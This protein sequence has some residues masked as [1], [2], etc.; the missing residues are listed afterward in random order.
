MSAVRPYS[1]IFT[2]A[3][4]HGRSS[5][6]SACGTPSSSAMTSTG[7]CP[8]IPVNRSTGSPAV[9]RSTMASTS[10]PASCSTQGRS[11]STCPRA[12]AALISRRNRVWSGGSISR[13][14]L[15]WI[16]LNWPN[17]SAGARSVQIRP[18]ARVRSTAFASACP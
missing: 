8:A 9:D 18:S 11:R 7:S 10:S 1:Y 13:I 5:G 14:A 12:N 6:R 15:R 4:D 16:R 17:R 2:M 3:L